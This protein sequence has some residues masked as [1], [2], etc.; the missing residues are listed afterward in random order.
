MRPCATGACRSSAT[1]ATA[2][3]VAM[4]RA[5][6]RRRPPPRRA[7]R[8]WV[9]DRPGCRTPA[10]PAPRAGPLAAAGCAV[11][12]SPRLPDVP[13]GTLRGGELCVRGGGRRDPACYGL[14]HRGHP[15]GLRVDVQEQMLARRDDLARRRLRHAVKEV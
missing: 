9:P 15:P 7:A 3:T 11:G 4:R 10:A 12:V 6:V 5:H 8:G 1:P 14:D 2:R 13:P